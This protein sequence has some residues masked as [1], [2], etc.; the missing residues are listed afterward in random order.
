MKSTAGNASN[1][2]LPTV[3][4]WSLIDNQRP[5]PTQIIS[6]GNQQSSQIN[7]AFTAC[8]LLFEVI[9]FPFC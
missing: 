1:H 3:I 2:K 4:H 6:T 8:R 5:V 9:V 7:A